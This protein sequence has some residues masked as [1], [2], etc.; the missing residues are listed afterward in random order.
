MKYS[1][2]SKERQL[3]IEW[4]CHI[5]EGRKHIKFAKKGTEVIEYITNNKDKL[6]KKLYAL[7]DE[8]YLTPDQAKHF[9]YVMKNYK[10]EPIFKQIPKI[11]NKEIL[12]TINQIINEL[13]AIDIVYWDIHSRN[14]LIKGNKVVVID[15]DEAKLGVEPSR[16]SNARFNYV[17][18]IIELYIGYLLDKN[19]RYISFF[20]DNLTIENY[21][22][23]DVCDYI[24]S[25]NSYS[26]EQVNR[27][28][29]FLITEFEDHERIDYLKNQV[30]ELIK[31]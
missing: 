19:I 12:L 14:F 5:V 15:L 13:L 28:P 25:I 24:K 1:T 27:D 2:C 4:K 30:K 3:K 8:I 18:L 17:D 31:R 6:T 29:S 7:A 23:K 22:S 21:F 10:Y 20:I 16:L 9:A 26:K 11:N